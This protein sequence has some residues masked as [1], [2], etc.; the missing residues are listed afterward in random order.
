MIG[1]VYFSFKITKSKILQKKVNYSLKLNDSKFELFRG[2]LSLF[3][4]TET[5]IH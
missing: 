3:C 2:Q 4:S 1:M 5:R